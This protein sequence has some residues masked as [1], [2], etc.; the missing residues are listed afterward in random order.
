MTMFDYRGKELCISRG[1]R[2]YREEQL[3]IQS[4]ITAAP[5]R[6]ESRQFGS[7]F[8][9]QCYNEKSQDWK[10]LQDH[11]GTYSNS[12][13][14]LRQKD[15]TNLTTDDL[16]LSMNEL[17]PYNSKQKEVRKYETE[18]LCLLQKLATKSRVPSK[19]ELL[20][21]LLDNFKRR[22]NECAKNTEIVKRYWNKKKITK[23]WVP[24]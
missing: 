8:L 17:V 7:T 1:L 15:L 3:F 23:T 22:I 16:M 5:N 24:C 20:K 18:L 10:K 4:E 11:S 6:N 2:E 21:M 12:C 14:R 19:E 9:N 13:Q